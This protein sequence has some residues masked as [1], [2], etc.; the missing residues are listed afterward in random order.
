MRKVGAPALAFSLSSMSAAPPR[1]LALSS[2]AGQGRAGAPAV[3]AT[4][5]GAA[6]G[7]HPGASPRFRA[8]ARPIRLAPRQVIDLPKERERASWRKRTKAWS[9]TIAST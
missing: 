6:A 7:G 8:C 9:I 4:S 1:S 2:S 3:A 5:A